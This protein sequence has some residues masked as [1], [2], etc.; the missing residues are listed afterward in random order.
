MINNYPFLAIEKTIRLFFLKSPFEDI[1]NLLKK[2]LLKKL[3]FC[4]ESHFKRL[5]FYNCLISILEKKETQY[6]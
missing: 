5:G 2:L 1:L 3:F 4:F 6:L